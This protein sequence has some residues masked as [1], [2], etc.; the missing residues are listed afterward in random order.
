MNI[1]AQG[2]NKPCLVYYGISEYQVKKQVESPSFM[3]K[4]NFGSSMVNM[5]KMFI[6]ETCYVTI[7]LKWLLYG[8]ILVVV[9]REFLIEKRLN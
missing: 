1:I 4:S 3:T 5:V 7:V 8:A 2:L 6:P 9:S